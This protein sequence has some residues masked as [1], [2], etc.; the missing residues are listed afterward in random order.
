MK[1]LIDIFYIIIL[2]LKKEHKNLAIVS[3][4]RLTKKANLDDIHSNFICREILS[5]C[6]VTEAFF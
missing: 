6:R 1:K 5:Y 4:K 2:I 3:Y